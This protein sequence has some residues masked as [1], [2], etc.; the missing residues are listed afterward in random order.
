[1]RLAASHACVLPGDESFPGFRSRIHEDRLQGNG[2]KGQRRMARPADCMG[3]W[4]VAVSMLFST[5]SGFALLL[6]SYICTSDSTE[7]DFPLGLEWVNS[8]LLIAEA[9]NIACIKRKTD[10]AQ[11]RE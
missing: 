4:A 10:F 6:S 5:S 11:N 7:F 2:D 1:M 9:Q 8:L 3:E